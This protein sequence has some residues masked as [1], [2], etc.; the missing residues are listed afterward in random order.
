MY[1]V[2]H[3][4]VF[5][6]NWIDLPHVFKHRVLKGK[7]VPLNCNIKINWEAGRVSHLLFEELYLPL[8]KI[9]V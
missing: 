5:T 1:L 4:S 2:T 7:S 9:L 8:Y 6:V 3:N